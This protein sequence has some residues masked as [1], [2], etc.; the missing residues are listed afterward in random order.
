MRKR[1][2]VAQVAL[3]SQAFSVVI[4]KDVAPNG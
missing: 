3:A 4:T 1:R 2:G